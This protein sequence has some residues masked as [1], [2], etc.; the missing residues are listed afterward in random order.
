MDFIDKEEFSE[1]GNLKKYGLHFL[2]G[3]LMRLFKYDKV[4]EL[5]R[6]AYHEDPIV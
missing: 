1:A 4:N 5:Y 3:P 2:A 6:N